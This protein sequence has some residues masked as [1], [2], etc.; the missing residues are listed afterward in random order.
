MRGVMI[1]AGVLLIA[2][3][4]WILY[5]FGAFLIYTAYQMAREG[6]PEVHPEAN[7]VLRLLRRFVPM[8]RRY[9]G[10]RFFV[11]LPRRAGGYGG[12]AATPL[13]AVLLVVETTDV[14][15]AL[16]SIPAIFAVTRD[17]FIIYTSNV[18]AILG[19]RS[20][21]FV[22][23][24]VIRK[25]RYLRPALAVVLGFVGTK[26]MLSDV[27]HVPAAA[28]LGVVVAILAAAV[29]ASLARM[30]ASAPRD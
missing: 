17:P 30:P 8:T 6:S 7:P 18:F 29:L 22:V 5:L 16:D 9:A 2:K 13:L 11:R 23:A 1:G 10:Q 15:F 12:Y 28:S 27:V 25:F 3:F 20:M 4:H 14:M 19:L 26:M 21:Y 24:A